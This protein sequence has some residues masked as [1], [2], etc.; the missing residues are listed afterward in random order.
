MFS[1]NWRGTHV[2][3]MHSKRPQV[4]QQT[5]GFT[6][7]WNTLIPL[8]KKE[9]V[10]FCFCT[11]GIHMHLVY[12]KCVF[13][14]QSW[15]NFIRK[16]TIYTLLPWENTYFQIESVDYLYTGLYAFGI[17]EILLFNC[18]HEDTTLK[19]K[20]S[21]YKYVSLVALSKSRNAHLES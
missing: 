2:V 1:L 6:G 13:S 8:E 5:E 4:L 20:A 12:V 19:C 16:L 7:F 9:R 21:T 3:V 10:Y 11:N 17:R 15:L 14:V 18:I